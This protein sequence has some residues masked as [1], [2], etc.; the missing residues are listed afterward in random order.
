VKR[1]LN[2]ALGVMTAIGG[3][4]DIGNLV[5]SGV[6]G[7]RF[8]L[9]LV[10]A[11]AFGTVAMT[12]YGEM[13]GRVTAVAGRPVFHL[14]RERLGVRMA[15][16]NL[17]ASLLLNL[18]TVAAELGGVGLALYL[19]SSISYI[20]WVPIIGFLV[21]FLIW[22]VP[23]SV[24]DRVFGLLGLALVVFVVALVKLHPDWHA[25]GS[26]I[27]HPAVPAGESHVT[28][29]FYAISLIGAC[30]VPYQVFFFSS[31]AIE[32]GWSE[33][34]LFD[35]RL[36]ALIGFPLG[37]AL[38]LAIMAAAVPVL[39]PAGIQVNHLGQVALPVAVAL[40]KLGLI[41]ALV[42]FFAATFA[43]AVE[44]ALSSGYIIAQYLGWSW[45]KF[46]TPAQAPRFH[47][48]CLLTVVL[49]TGLILTTIDPVKITIISVVLGAA[50][51]PLTFFP[52]IVVANDREYM[53]EHVNRRWTNVLA[54]IIFCVL[55]A[56]S[57]ATVPLLF[58]TKAGQ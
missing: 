5:T 25:M 9:S 11:L 39:E 16:V 17:V 42:G 40:G 2:L 36:N 4:V 10:W 51:V 47:V 37:G 13:A 20:L 19:A 58:W 22:R 23:F 3:F 43:A 57:V 31:G 53:G 29:F 35:M 26:A 46:R 28:W 50:A 33:K 49:S 32:E 24:I 44:A 18:L 8:G 41:I 6:T 48:A 12:V 15:M 45:G 34:N 21:W 55:V 14:V 38:S 52:V 30:V 27:V 54:M 7:A 1:L 56:V